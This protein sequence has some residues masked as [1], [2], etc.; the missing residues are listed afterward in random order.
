MKKIRGNGQPRR[1]RKLAYISTRNLLR[2]AAPTSGGGEFYV[3]VTDAPG[4]QV[5]GLREISFCFLHTRKRL[6]IGGY[7]ASLDFVWKNS[8]LQEAERKLDATHPIPA[9]AKRVIVESG[10]RTPHG[11]AYDCEIDERWE[12][13]LAARTAELEAMLEDRDREPC[14]LVPG[15][16]VERGHVFAVNAYGLFDKSTVTHEDIAEFIRQYRLVG[17]PLQHG[18]SVVMERQADTDN[19]PE[20]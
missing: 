4:D 11:F 5:H 1:V 10:T 17:Q 12:N 13:A 3:V 2:K 19:A 20:I 8:L 18:F 16:V 6:A 15:L 14:P 9:T 7:I